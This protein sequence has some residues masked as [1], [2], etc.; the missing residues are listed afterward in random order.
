[1]Q[2][3]AAMDK[4][5]VDLRARRSGEDALQKSRRRFKDNGAV[6]ELL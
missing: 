6:G 2:I 1:M 5:A 4:I 3:P